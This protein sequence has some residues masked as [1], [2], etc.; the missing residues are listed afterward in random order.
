MFLCATIFDFF[1]FLSVGSQL[2]I[3]IFAPPDL[4]IYKARRESAPKEKTTHITSSLEHKRF[5][6]LS[7]R[8]SVTH[9][10]GPWLW[11]ISFYGLNTT[12]LMKMAKQ[13]PHLPL[14]LCL[15][16]SL[17]FTTLNPP[18]LCFFLSSDIPS[19]YPIPGFSSSLWIV[20]TSR[21]SSN[22]PWGRVPDIDAMNGLFC[23]MLSRCFAC[24]L[25]R[26]SL[27][28]V[29]LEFFLQILKICVW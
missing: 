14:P 23:F 21:S 7:K 8:Q 20:L 2:Q 27:R 18:I 17:H 1:F 15:F 9:Q 13:H 3:P 4:L 10:R 16:L 29:R 25:Y 12:C 24:V 5:W 19:Y 6:R 11:T 28:R 26:E 22:C